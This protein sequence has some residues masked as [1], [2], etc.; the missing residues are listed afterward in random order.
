MTVF[1]G[2]FGDC[3]SCQEEYVPLCP[4][5]GECEACC[6]CTYDEDEQLASIQ[7]S[8]RSSASSAVPASSPAGSQPENHG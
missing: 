1:I 6:D 4:E 2:N 8:L 3:P 5:C 7:Q